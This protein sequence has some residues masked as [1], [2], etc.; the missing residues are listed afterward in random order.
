MENWLLAL[1]YGILVGVSLGLTG[2]GGSILAVPLLLYGLGVPLRAAVA[3]SLAVVGLTALYGAIL[4][5]RSGQ[6]VWRAGWIIGLGGILAAPFGAKIG[7]ALPEQVTLIA[8]AGLM[9]FIGVMMFLKNADADSVL[10]R[11]ACER[12]PEGLPR[13]SIL[14]AG[15]LVVAGLLV[16]LLSGIFGVGGGFLIVPAILFT[17]AVSIERALATSLVAI[18]LISTSALAANWSALAE[19]TAAIPLVFL[20]GSLAGLTMGTQVKRLLPTQVLGRGFAGVVVLVALAML[21]R[22]L[23][24]L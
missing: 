2:G 13:F 3:V 16:G 18:F 14:C 17:A 4:Q 8:F 15:K 23:L 24:A 10:M 9:L 20:A 7:A 21:G 22:E 12:T 19:V 11:L 5:A 1:G 6:V